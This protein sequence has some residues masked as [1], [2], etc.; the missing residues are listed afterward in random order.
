MPVKLWVSQR[1]GGLEGQFI[2]YNVVTSAWNGITSYWWDEERLA[3]AFKPFTFVITKWY[4]EPSQKFWVNY[5]LKKLE[6]LGLITRSRQGKE[7]L[8]ATTPAGQEACR[9][10]REIR[11][12]C[13]VTSLEAFAG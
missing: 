3:N 4:I 6:K 5:A 13:L 1:P 7:N 2:F 10:Y 9:K 8:Y 12:D 11:E